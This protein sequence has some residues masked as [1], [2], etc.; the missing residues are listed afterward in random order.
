MEGIISNSNL[1]NS[2]AIVATLIF[3]LFLIRKKVINSELWG[4]TVTPLASIIGS[5]FLIVAPLL[6]SV[7]GKWAPMGIIVLLVLAYGIGRVIRFNILHAEGLEFSSHPFNLRLEKLSQIVLGIAY[8]ISVAFYISLFTSFISREFGIDNTQT[9][10]WITTATLLSVMGVSWW[11]GTKGL[12]RIELIAVTIKLAVIGGV[13]AALA[14]FDIATQ[15]HW[16]GHD[17]IKKL[18]FFEKM[19]MLAGMLMV[20]QGFE[21]TRFMGEHYSKNIRIQA[22]RNSQWIA[23]AIYILFIGLT[24]P[25]FLDFPIVELNETTISQSLGRAVSVLPLLLLGAAI[26]SQLSAAL[27]DTIGAGGLLKEII[28]SSLSI[29]FYYMVV[30]GSAIFLIWSANVFEIINLAS[31]GF[32]GFFFLQILVALNLIRQKLNGSKQFFSI[33]GCLI[34]EAALIFVIFFSIP[35]PHS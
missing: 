32:A 3:G 19:A 29:N 33:L 10:K 7:F 12:E 30:I 1:F 22:S 17:P 27:A 11:R 16:F 5:G 18:T 13:L 31:K 15:T 34:L 20:T 2:I 6:H 35:A 28:P 21:T 14:S 26:A 25:I 4:A 24:C 23:I 9:M 8:A